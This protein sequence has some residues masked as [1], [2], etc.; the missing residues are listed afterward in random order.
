M[1]KNL[2][3]DI[4]DQS[5][6][7]ITSFYKKGGKMKMI[8]YLKLYKNVPDEIW[9]PFLIYL[10][11]GIGIFAVSYFIFEKLLEGYKGNPLLASII[12][13]ISSTLII[14]NSSKKNDKEYVSY[15]IES[16]AKFEENFREV[17]DEIRYRIDIPNKEEYINLILNKFY[18]N[19]DISI[20][21][22]E[23]LKKLKR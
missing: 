1:T 16:R 6:M 4:I 5:K 18:G 2:L 11:I 14:T 23:I 15:G 12:M 3:N 21:D 10:L 9:K 20:K 22:E 13:L 17:S 8:D 7:L 19:I